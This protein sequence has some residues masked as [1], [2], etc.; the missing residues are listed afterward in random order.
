MKMVVIGGTGLVGSKVVSAL[1]ARGHEAA[2][3]SSRSGV[4]TLTGEGVVEALPGANV[5]IDVSNS[6]SFEDTAILAFFE[7]STRN[8][9]AGAAATGVQHYV[10]LSVVG[11]DRLAES[12]YFRARIAQETLIRESRRSL[13]DRS[14]HPVLRVP[15]RHCGRRNR[16]QGRTAG[17]SILPADGRCRCGRECDAGCACRHR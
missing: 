16:W 5:V 12:G 14:R 9:L 10:A 1:R 15:R 7:T 2:A 4:N 8:L 11:T 13:H 17:A 6:S 3:P